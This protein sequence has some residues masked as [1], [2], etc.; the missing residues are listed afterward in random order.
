MATYDMAPRFGQALRR[1][2]VLHKAR[3][4]EALSSRRC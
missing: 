4:L 1:Y 2:R 3:R